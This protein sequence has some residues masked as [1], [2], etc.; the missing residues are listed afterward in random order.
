MTNV[1]FQVQPLPQNLQY[2]VSPTNQPEQPPVLPLVSSAVS[3]NQR[4]QQV[5]LGQPQAQVPVFLASRNSPRSNSPRNKR[6]VV[7]ITQ[8]FLRG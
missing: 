4:N 7:S 8:S 5:F 2:L 1:S 3:H 6:V